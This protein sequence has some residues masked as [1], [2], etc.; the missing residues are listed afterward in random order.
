MVGG[1][2]LNKVFCQWTADC[3]G[4]DIYTGFPE[5]TISGNAIVQL[6]ALGEIKT[7]EEGRALIRDSYA[8]KAYSPGES[9]KDRWDSLI[10]KYIDLKERDR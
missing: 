3:L 10:T 9:R 5:S 6:M 1:G 2:S 4:K 7:I 8:E